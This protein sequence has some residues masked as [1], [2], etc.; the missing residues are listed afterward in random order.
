MKSGCSASNAS[1]VCSADWRSTISCH[2]T[3]RSS[4]QATSWPVRRTTSTCS[5]P[6]SARSTAS[7]TA[8]RLQRRGLAAPPAAV[9]GDDDLGVR[10]LDAGCERVRRETAEHHRVRGADPRAG[11]HRDRGLRDHRHV[12]GDPVALLNSQLQQGVRGLGDLVLQLRV[13]DRAAVAGLALEVDGDPVAVARLDVPVHAV[14]RHVERAVLEPLGERRVRPVQRL[15]RF[16]RPAEAAGLRGPEAE[17]VSLGLLIRLRRDIGVRRQ[18]GGGANLR[19]S[20][21]RLARLSLLTASAFPR[22]SVVSRA[23]S[24]DPGSDDKGRRNIGLDLSSDPRPETRGK[25]LSYPRTPGEPGSGRHVRH[26]HPV[27]QPAPVRLGQQV[28]LRLADMEIHPVQLQ[29]PPPARPDPPTRAPADAPTAAPHWSDTAAL[30]RRRAPFPSAVPRVGRR[31]PSAPG[32]APRGAATAS[33]ASGR[34]RARS[35][36]APAWPRSRSARTP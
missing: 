22:V 4:F 14:V 24:S 32:S 1:G 30:R 33:T 35:R 21:N 34:P 9:R 6:L 5:T 13:G 7:S 11:Q 3:S 27:E 15:G 8:G 16:L 29:R 18:V 10:V 31:R 20:R 12:D 19:S 36:A 25:G 28:R 2:H 23:S 17:P 26:P